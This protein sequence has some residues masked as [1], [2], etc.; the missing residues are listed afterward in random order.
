[1][2]TANLEAINHFF[3]VHQSS[4][5]CCHEPSETCRQPAIRAHSIPN[6]SVLST[7]MDDGHII[8]PQMKLKKHQSPEIEFKRVGRNKATTF[9]GLCST[10]D[11]A[12]FRPIDTEKPNSNDRSH[13]FLLAYRAVLREYHACLQNGL[14]SQSVYQNHVELGLSSNTEPSDLGMLAIANLANAYESYEYKKVFDLAYLSSD[15][16]QFMHHV[17]VFQNQPATIAVNSMFSLDG[18]D[19]PVTPRVTLNVYPT[20]GDVIVIFSA[21]ATDAPFVAGYI[22]P[23]LSAEVYYQKYLL[24]KLILQ[25]CENFV[26]APRYY[27]S[28][29]QESKDALLR[30]FIDSIQHNAENHEDERLYLF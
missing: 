15:W 10:H 14:R 2:D 3:R 9:S 23:I 22:S 30:F 26:I 1:M 5:D 29:P 12:I 20:D 25:S 13:L 6:G 24:S 16:S 4:T 27:D 21:T 7:L 17:I 18:I 19:A 11:N 8:M 28:L